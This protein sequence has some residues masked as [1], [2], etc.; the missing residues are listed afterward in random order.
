MC[1]PVKD[2][3]CFSWKQGRVPK[4]I[5]NALVWSTGWA[6]AAKLQQ[7]RGVVNI[8]KELYGKNPCPWSKKWRG[9][10]GQIKTTHRH[11]PLGENGRAHPRINARV[12]S[13]TNKRILENF[14]QGKNSWGAQIIRRLLKRGAFSG[15]CKRG[16]NI[17]QS[18]GGV[19]LQNFGNR[20]PTRHDAEDV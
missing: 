3:L 20:I 12:A 6:G 15:K 10:V 19:I 18:K 16:V 13:N 2:T 17:L 4:T 1:G 9:V 7:P 14:H 11:P 8:K 5:A